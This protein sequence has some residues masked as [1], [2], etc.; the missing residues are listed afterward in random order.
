MIGTTLGPY[1]I[2]SK[3]GEGGMGEVFEA[4]D[5]RL[6][7]TVA[8]KLLHATT[9]SDRSARDR[10]T[11]EAR[12][13]SALTHPHICTLYDVGV[14]YNRDYLVMERVEGPTLAARL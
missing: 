6:N 12:A 4:I 9:E 2:V 3:L 14:H 1:R 7:R 11:R 5:T 13:I 10:L 8:I